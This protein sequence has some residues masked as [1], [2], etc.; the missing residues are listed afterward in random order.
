M[1]I[2]I[3][4]KV[5]IMQPYFFPYIGYY[6]LIANSDRFIYF[7]TPQYIRKGW[8]NRNRIINDKGEASYITVPVKKCEQKT[9][10]KDVEINYSMSWEEKIIGQLTVYKKRAPYYNDVVEMIKELFSKKYRTISDL[11]INSIRSSCERI[12]FDI[13]DDIYS[14][15]K[16]GID[17]VENPDE[18]ALYISKAIGAETY[19]N[20][21]GGLTFFDREKYEREG[22]KLQFL[23]ATLVPY[24]Q[25]IGYFSSGLSIL[26]VMMFCKGKEIQE[27]CKEYTLL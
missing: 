1:I 2:G 18:W 6:S 10:I 27:M 21:P 9:A 20:P 14:Q 26:D 4:V 8:I 23:Q 16:L 15:M 3:L 7:D 24:V 5:A 25:K 22:I 12:G 11:S 17:E 13:K 19:I